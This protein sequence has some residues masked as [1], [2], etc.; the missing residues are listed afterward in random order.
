MR[1][2]PSGSPENLL[3]SQSGVSLNEL[4]IAI[5]VA[6]ILALIAVPSY[7]TYTIGITENQ[8]LKEL[9]RF[10]QTKVLD[11]STLPPRLKYLDAH[12]HYV[13]TMGGENIY[14]SLPSAY[15]Y[16]G[17]PESM[18]I[19]DTRKVYVALSIRELTDTVSLFGDDVKINKDVA[20]IADRVQATLVSNDFEIVPDNP[21]VQAVRQSAVTQWSWGIRAKREG[22]NSLTINVSAIVKVSGTDTPLVLKTYSKK[23]EVSVKPTQRVWSFLKE[24]A[25][26]IWA[27][28][29]ALGG[30]LLWLI[31]NFAA[32][33]GPAPL[34]PRT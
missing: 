15:T 10:F 5:S 1:S 24:N 9:D 33:K 7:Q 23:I 12:P 26:W 3:G 21:P 25:A 4:L 18:N 2:N 34:K 13:R 11:Q 29:A 30:G 17:A 31:K 27:P 28:L 8:Q 14:K 6:I 20:K 16:V 19:D 22:S 32:R